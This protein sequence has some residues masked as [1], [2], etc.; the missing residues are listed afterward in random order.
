MSGSSSASEAELTSDLFYLSNQPQPGPGGDNADCIDIKKTDVE[1]IKKELNDLQAY[2]NKYNLEELNKDDL[3]QIKNDLSKYNLHV[4]SKLHLNTF[5]AEL[6]N[7]YHAEL[8]ILRE[9]Y[10]NKI[11]LINLEHEK[12][13]QTLER[14]YE[15]KIENLQFELDETLKNTAI[16][17]SNAVQEVVSLKKSVV[18][19]DDVGLTI[20]KKR[21]SLTHVKCR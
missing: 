15:E 5:K 20:F 10:E 9:D 16:S 12:K 1:D 18:E 3:T 19:K 4:L 21:M 8:E 11:D 7:K 17:V 2:L 6:Q 13:H 14:K